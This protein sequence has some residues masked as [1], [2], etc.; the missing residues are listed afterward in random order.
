MHFLSLTCFI[1]G[2]TV[3]HGNS[4]SYG[5]HHHLQKYIRNTYI[6]PLVDCHR[7]VLLLVISP[8]NPHLL[9][10]L[11]LL[12]CLHSVYVIKSVLSSID[13]SN[14]MFSSLLPFGHNNL[15]SITRSSLSSHR[16]FYY[17]IEFHNVYHI[18]IRYL[19]SNPRLLFSFLL[20]VRQLIKYLII[21]INNTRFHSLRQRLSIK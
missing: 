2:R 13:S 9:L 1:L 3:L 17:R 4:S 5:L 11:L 12:H 10:L 20:L 21:I 14:S 7:S 16:L 8:F 19:L 18:L 6:S 15:P